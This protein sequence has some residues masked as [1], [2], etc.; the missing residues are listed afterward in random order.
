MLKSQLENTLQLTLQITALEKALYPPKKNSGGKYFENSLLQLTQSCR[1]SKQRNGDAS[2][3]N[4]P[5]LDKIDSA[6][7]MMPIGL[8]HI[9]AQKVQKAKEID[10]KR[11]PQVPLPNNVEK[12]LNVFK[13]E[14][15]PELLPKLV[16]TTRK[17]RKTSFLAVEDELLLQGVIFY[18]EKDFA[19]IQAHCL[20]GKTIA[21]ISCRFKNLT[22]RNQASSKIKDFYLMPFKPMTYNEKFWLRHVAFR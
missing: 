20:P 19:S 3:A 4:I 6:V 5:G 14:F 8:N 1:K 13:D 9:F 7:K 22:E 11:K 15:K 16:P 2:V 17:D 21:Q 10:T 18:G 12:I